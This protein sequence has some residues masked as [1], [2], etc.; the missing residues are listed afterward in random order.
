MLLTLFPD[1]NFRT[2]EIDRYNKILGAEYERVRDF[3]V[4]HYST[5]QRNDGDLW[6][7][8]RNVALPDSLKERIDLFRSHGRILREDFEL[9]PTQSWLFVFVG[10]NIMPESDDPLVAILDPTVV[11]DNLTDIRNV[12]RQCAHAMPAHEDFINQ[13]CS[14]AA[15]AAP[16]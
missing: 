13:H 2:A 7:Y 12:V 9:F 4:L 1:R 10:Q 11:N 3:L 14:A 15:A 5:T 6:R 16:G 8:C